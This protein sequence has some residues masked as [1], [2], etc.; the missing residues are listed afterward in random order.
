MP[1]LIDHNVPESEPQIDESLEESFPASD[2][3][4]IGGIT[5]IEESDKPAET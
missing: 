5:K 2:P 4:A 3:P 1:K